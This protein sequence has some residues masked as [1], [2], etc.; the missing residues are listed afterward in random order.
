MQMGS[1]RG[2]IVRGSGLRSAEPTAEKKKK[3]K[4]LIG[5]KKQQSNGGGLASRYAVLTVR[6]KDLFDVSRQVQ[7]RTTDIVEDDADAE[8]NCQFGHVPDKEDRGTSAPKAIDIFAGSKMI[9]IQVFDGDKL[10]A[11]DKR[12]K[13]KMKTARVPVC[14]GKA[15]EPQGNMNGVRFSESP[16][17]RAGML[18][19]LDY[20]MDGESEVEVP[21][22]YAGEK[23]GLPERAG[24]VTLRLQYT[25][26]PTLMARS[27]ATLTKSWYFEFTV[28][29]MCLLAM[30]ALA[31]RAPAAPPSPT[32]FAALRITELFIAT[33]MVVE[34]LLEVEGTIAAGEKFLTETWFL[35]ALFILM[36]NW[37]SILMPQ[38]SDALVQV[39]PAENAATDTLTQ[40]Q[41]LAGALANQKTRKLISVGRV[42]RV[43]RPI[44]TLRLV[45]H[46][47]MIVSTL[48]DSMAIFGTVR[49]HAR[50]LRH[51]PE[52]LFASFSDSSSRV[53]MHRAGLHAHRLSAS[54][55]CAGGHLKFWGRVAVRVPRARRKWCLH[56]LRGATSCR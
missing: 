31:L 38:E 2:E 10:S 49:L 28:L 9:E 55:L 7:R 20:T 23:G 32:L 44:R 46:V 53:V 25:A 45:P 1:L 43:V 56:M 21:M 19:D 3:G 16:T 33:H 41:H 4:G 27:A 22:V 42:F 24:T 50:L 8:W 18:P 37:I 48:E 29:G 17:T 36:C 40:N 15:G 6:T 14:V 34:L 12:D 30:V 5:W 54:N 26:R 13:K 52:I 11:A 51:L 39:M 35:L 47:D